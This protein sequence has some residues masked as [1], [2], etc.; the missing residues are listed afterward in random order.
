MGLGIGEG[1]QVV[2]TYPFFVVGAIHLISSA[3]LGAGAFFHAFRGPEDLAETKGQVKKFDFS[4]DDPKQLGLILGHHLLFLGAGAL[5]FAWNAMH[6][7]GLYDPTLKAVRLVSEPMLDPMTI[8]GYQTHFATVSRLEDI[9]GGHLYVAFMLIGGGIWHI[10]VPPLAWAKQLLIFSS[11]A[12][13]SY[14]LGGIALAADFC[15]VNTTAYPVEFFGDVLQVKFGVSPYF[16]DTVAL[17]LTQHTARAWLANAHFF[18][19]FFLFAGTS[20]AC[21]AGDGV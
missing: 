1:G 2:D 4:W 13:L 9:V 10:L 15:A 21:A 6:G 20:M 7:T 14:A 17:P 16:A 8:Y 11:E 18:L 3:V 5:L 19:A 12:I